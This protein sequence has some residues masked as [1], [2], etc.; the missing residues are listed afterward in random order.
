VDR[1]ASPD[2]PSL[3]KM[4]IYIDEIRNPGR[5]CELTD[6]VRPWDIDFTILGRGGG[7]GQR[8]HEVGAY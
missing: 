8:V 7:C 4:T 1:Q 6:I 5:M 2:S 3:S